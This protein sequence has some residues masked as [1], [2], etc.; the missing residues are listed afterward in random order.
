MKTKQLKSLRLQK[1]AIASLT[2]KKLIGGVLFT[3]DEAVDT[4]FGKTCG[5]C[6]EETERHCTDN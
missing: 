3:Q 1:K 2:P 4:C 6:E 5:I